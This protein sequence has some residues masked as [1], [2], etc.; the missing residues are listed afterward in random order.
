MSAQ[1]SAPNVIG[2]VALKLTKLPEQDQRLVLELVDYLEEQ[3]PPASAKPKT[4]AK[5]RKEARHRAALLKDV[6]REQLVA[7]FVELGD[8]IRR[9]AI[10]RGTAIEGDWLGD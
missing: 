10:R 4:P 2:R 5:I 6:P 7:R 3:H 1:Q 8:E 9:E